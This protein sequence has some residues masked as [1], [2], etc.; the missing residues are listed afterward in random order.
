MFTAKQ[1]I[2]APNPMPAVYKTRL[3]YVQ[4]FSP[5]TGIIA[6][7][8]GTDQSMRLNSLHDPDFSLGGHQPYGFDQ[9][10]AFYNRYLVTRALVELSITEPSADGLVF[11]VSIRAPSSLIGL[12]GA[13]VDAVA[14]RQGCITRFLNNSGSQTA[15]MRFDLP[16]HELLGMSPTAYSGARSL[17]GAAVG[18]DPSLT[19]YLT[20]A[21][22]NMANSNNESM[23]VQVRIT[24]ECELTDRL[25]YSPS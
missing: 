15:Y 13:T 8:F 7:Y 20:F 23:I 1:L 3:R 19:P 16:M 2:A 9:M 24:F 10:A 12:S 17:Y 22:A 5:N 11:G 25:Q 4:T 21:V 6:N 18:A 14:E